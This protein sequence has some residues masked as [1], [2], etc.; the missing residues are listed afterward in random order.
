ME[1]LKRLVKEEEGQGLVEYTLI[2]LLVA[3]VFWVAIQ[4]TDVGAQLALS[5]TSIKECLADPQLGC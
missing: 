2:V 1:L 5:W 4:N 3:L